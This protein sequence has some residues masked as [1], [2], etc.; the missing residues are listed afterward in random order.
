MKVAL[1]KPPQQGSLQRGVGFYAQ[2]LFD[3]LNQ[4]QVME[5]N[6]VDFSF[7]PLSYQKFDIVHF[8]YFDEFFFTLP[9][10]LPQKTVISILDCTKLKFPGHFPAGLRGKVAWPWQKS[11]ATRAA[12]IITLSESAKADIKTFFGSQES[13]I[14]VTYLAA[15]EIF[16]P[17]KSKREN[18]VLYVG[19]VN[20]N[21]NVITLIR[22]CQ[23]IKMPLVLVGKE[24]LNKN[25][26]FSNIENQSFIEI[27]KLVQD[28]KNIKMLGFVPTEGLVDLYNRAKVYVQ[29][30]VYE[31]FGLPI[32]EAMSCGTP[33]ICGKNS[34]LTEIAGD[35]ATYADVTD[36]NDLASKIE[37]IEPTGKEIFQARKFSWEKTA[38]ETVKVYEKVLA[39]L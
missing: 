17:L 14:N 6:W 21:K 29:P 32:L 37:T 16:K 19:G 27:L 35:A 2:R 38:T 4:R 24:F 13:K 31:G 9:P 11:L 8:P 36:V 28:D 5:I 10:F 26:D 23:K 20:W 34:S 15:D 1:V 33:A 7:N 22:A 39:G 30:S 3:A 18:F 12:A 25:V